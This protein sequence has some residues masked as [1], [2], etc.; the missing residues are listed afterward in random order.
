MGARIG[1]VPWNKGL[2]KYTDDRM[3][4]MA[5]HV[6]ISCKGRIPWNKGLTKEIDSR[7]K[8]PANCITRGMLGHIHSQE[9]KALIRTKA[10]GRPSW[11]KGLTKETDTRLLNTSL[12]MKGHFSDP[13]YCK[14]ILHRR[15]MSSGEEL[16][17]RMLAP[18]FAFVGNGKLWIGGKNPDFAAVDGSSKLIELWGDYFH[19]GQNPFNRILYFKLFGFDTLVIWASELG[20]IKN[21]SK[22][23][24]KVQKFLEMS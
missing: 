14:R 9:S 22:V 6:S 3:L 18:M 21:R 5:K 24:L 4:E 10:L 16:M 13:S 17:S 8:A 7:I 2:T 23:L 20:T 1:S 19:K 11:S 15:S 12:K